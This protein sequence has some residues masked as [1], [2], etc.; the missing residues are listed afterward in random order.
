MKHD[1]PTNHHFGIVAH[2]Q[3]NIFARFLG[4][5]THATFVPSALSPV[6]LPSWLPVLISVV[7]V[8]L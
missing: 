8:E 5:Y 6:T 1:G 3:N 4:L 7:N 2:R